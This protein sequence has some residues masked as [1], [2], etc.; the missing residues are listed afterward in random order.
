M[1]CFVAV[2]ERVEGRCVVEY[3][4]SFRLSKCGYPSSMPAELVLFSFVVQDNSCSRRHDAVSFV[5]VR[6]VQDALKRIPTM[7][8]SC[9]DPITT[10]QPV[11]AP[12]Y[13]IDSRVCECGPT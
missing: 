9:S 6:G 11:Y 3:L 1:F 13:E 4:C 8:N 7:L 2:V 10:P 12:G 5:V